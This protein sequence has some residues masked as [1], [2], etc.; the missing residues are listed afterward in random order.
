[1]TGAPLAPPQSESA[2]DRAVRTAVEAAPPLDEDRRD[3]VSRLLS[4]A[5]VR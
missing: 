3:E 5:Q 2:L 4:K 1:M